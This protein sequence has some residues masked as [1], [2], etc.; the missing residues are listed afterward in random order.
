MYP[1]EPS[2]T[3]LRS[4]IHEEERQRAQVLAPGLAVRCGGVGRGHDVQRA[5]ACAAHIVVVM[6]DD[7]L[8]RRVVGMG[9]AA[10]LV[11]VGHD[12]EVVVLCP[13]LRLRVLL[14]HLERPLTGLGPAPAPYFYVL[15]RQPGDAPRSLGFG[16]ARLMRD[17]P[18]R[19]RSQT[20]SVA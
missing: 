17:A 11:R 18:R 16:H 15:G 8:V 6:V 20:R 2:I 12:L 3:Y 4:G 5:G 13:L 9:L 10:V 7:D 1:H 14:N 19:A